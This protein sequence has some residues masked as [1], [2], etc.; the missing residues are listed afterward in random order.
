[1]ILGT[2]KEASFWLKLENNVSLIHWVGVNNAKNCVDVI[3]EWSL[4]ED[5]QLGA[6]LG[7]V[8]LVLLAGHGSYL[9]VAPLLRLV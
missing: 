6:D 4:V 8:A 3:Y 1:M 5:V 7:D 9:L 2:V